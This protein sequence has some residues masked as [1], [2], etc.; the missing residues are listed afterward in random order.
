MGYKPYVFGRNGSVVLFN[1]FSPS[2]NVF[3]LQ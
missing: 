2:L 1:G 3:F